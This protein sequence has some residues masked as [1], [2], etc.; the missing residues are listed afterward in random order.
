MSC[1]QFEAEQRIRMLRGFRA[2]S[3]LS[4][5]MEALRPR[6]RFGKAIRDYSCAVWRF[7]KRL[8]VGWPDDAGVFGWCVTTGGEDQRGV[9]TPTTN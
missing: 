1:L 6:I 8:L 7:G 9:L 2:K 4:T 3:Q 5:P